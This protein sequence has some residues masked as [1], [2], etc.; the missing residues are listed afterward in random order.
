MKERTQL[1]LV[2]LTLP[3]QQSNLTIAFTLSFDYENPEIA[4]R[5]ANEFLTLILNEDARNHTNRAARNQQISRLTTEVKRPARC[6]G[7]GPIADDR[8]VIESR[9]IRLRRSRCNSNN[10]AL[11]LQK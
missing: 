6:C 9:R 5:V 10:S 11:N 1:K 2:D 4:T 7:F 8:G 3:T